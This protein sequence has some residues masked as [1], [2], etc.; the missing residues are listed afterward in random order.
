ME[1]K[2]VWVVT[3]QYTV[4]QY[5]T[6]ESTNTKVFFTKASAITYT[7]EQIKSILDKFDKGNC[8]LSESELEWEHLQPIIYNKLNRYNKYDCWMFGNVTF[9]L[10]EH[11]IL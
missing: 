11:D 8:S 3:K 2:K 9:E 10:S 1:N 6:K 4:P 5:R 7:I